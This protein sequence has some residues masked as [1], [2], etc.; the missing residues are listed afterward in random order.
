[1]TRRQ[2]AYQRLKK[3]SQKARD[4]PVTVAAVGIVL[5]VL[6]AAGAVSSGELQNTTP[7]PNVTQPEV[8]EGNDTVNKSDDNVTG[9]TSENSADS[10]PVNQSNTTG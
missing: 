9:N 10:T 7:E 6:A 2:E 1:M 3:W 4:R 5:V 8:P